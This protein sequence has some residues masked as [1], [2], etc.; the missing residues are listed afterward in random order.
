MKDRPLQ[1]LVV[2]DNPGDAEL[3][4]GCFHEAPPREFE[5]SHVTTLSSAE[6]HLARQS[7]DAVVLDLNLPD[8]LGTATLSRVRARWPDLPIVVLSGEVGGGPHCEALRAG[9]SEVVRKGERPSVLFRTSVLYAIERHRVVDQVRQS[10]ALVDKYPDAVLIAGANGVVRYVNEAAVALFARPKHELLGEQVSF[11]IAEDAPSEIT[12]LRKDSHRVAEIRLSTINWYE[13]RAVLAICR[14]ISERKQAELQMVQADRL[15]SM[16]TLVAGVAHE[17]NNP[18]VAVIANLG[19][20][21][22]QLEELS[23]DVRLPSDLTEELNDAIFAAERV[24][25]IVRDLKLFSRGNDGQSGPVDVER[26]LE[27]AFRMSLGETR[28]RARVVKDFARVPA[29]EGNETRLGQVF[30][31][32]IINAAQ[33]IPEG[34]VAR[35]EIRVTTSVDGAGRVVVAVSDTGRGIPLEAQRRLFTPFFTTKPVGE[36]TG[37]GLALAHQFVTGMGGQIGFTSVEGRGT[38]FRVTLCQADLRRR[39]DEP[40]KASVQGRRRGRILIVDDEP[41]VGRIVERS[42]STGHDVIFE[43]RGAQ[44]VSRVLGGERFDV[45]LCDLMMPEQTGM[46]VYEAIRAASLEQAERMVFITGGTAS[47]R[48]RAFLDEVPNQ[49]LEKPFDPQALRALVNGLLR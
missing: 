36:G 14:D 47:P 34:D 1:I 33:A 28:R 24:R 44:A 8:S 42:L 19:L 10:E 49:R 15:T 37:L 3:T 45:I 30:L 18:L 6:E 41:M 2:E 38:E 22:E 11:S 27:M 26:V 29:V 5:A 20:I 17:I 9:A 43:E 32:L 25:E 46:E 7:V 23:A 12:I 31:N 13:E 39:V 16:G 48:V 4:L 35:N 40:P 21:R